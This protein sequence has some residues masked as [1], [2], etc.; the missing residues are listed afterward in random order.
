MLK[1]SLPQTTHNSSS[2]TPISYDP[3]LFVDSLTNRSIQVKNFKEKGNRTTHRH[4][5]TQQ[6][7]E[8]TASNELDQCID[9]LK[10]TMTFRKKALRQ[11]LFKD[12]SRR[13]S[14][15]PV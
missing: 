14:S 7:Q 6:I 11:T 4:S 9:F 2:S 8:L 15:S 13:E 12:S 1:E 10:Q 5:K 3:F